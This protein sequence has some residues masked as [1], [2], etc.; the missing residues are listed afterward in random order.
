MLSI[1]QPLFSRANIIRSL[2]SPKYDIGVTK[3]VRTAGVPGVKGSRTCIAIG[4]PSLSR[5]SNSSGFALG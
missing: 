1:M 4:F 3:I 5:A 2:F